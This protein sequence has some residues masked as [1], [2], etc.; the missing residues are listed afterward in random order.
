[1]RK[2]FQEKLRGA[3]DTCRYEVKGKLYAWHVIWVVICFVLHFVCVK[4]ILY[5]QAKRRG[6]AHKNK[7]IK[8]AAKIFTVQTISMKCVFLLKDPIS[9]VHKHNKVP[10]WYK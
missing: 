8:S 6:A 10:L 2:S 4:C 5:K 1:M 3:R 7:W 9:D